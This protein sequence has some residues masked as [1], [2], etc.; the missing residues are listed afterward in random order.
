MLT[1]KHKKIRKREI[2]RKLYDSE[3]DV[4]KQLIIHGYK[5]GRQQRREFPKKLANGN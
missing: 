1:P 5:L 2:T 4:G 3:D